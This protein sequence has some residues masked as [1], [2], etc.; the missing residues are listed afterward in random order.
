MLSFSLEL[1]VAENH[2]TEESEDM[3][4]R[5]FSMIDYFNRHARDW[6]PRLAFDGG[7]KAGWESWH[8][9]ALNKLLDL[10]GDFPDPVTLESEV[11]YSIEDRGLIRERVIFDSEEHMS[12]PCI[13]LK[14][15]DMPSDKSAPPNRISLAPL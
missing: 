10:L 7:N 12:V 2:H 8:G 9:E 4:H 1:T 14:P 5:N 3:A 15:V 6:K 11:V 13:V